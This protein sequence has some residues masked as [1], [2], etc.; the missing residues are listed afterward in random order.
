MSLFNLTRKE[1]IIKIFDD[2][3]SKENIN[4]SEIRTVEK[5]KVTSHEKRKWN[6]KDAKYWLKYNID[7]DIL[8]KYNVFPLKSFTLSKNIDGKIN[9][10][11]KEK[12]Y[13]YGYFKNDGSIYKIYQPNSKNPFFKVSSYIQGTE[14]LEYKSK[15]LIICSSLKDMMSLESLNFNVESIAPSSENTMIPK[16]Q[17]SSLILKYDNIYTLFDND[18]AGYRASDKYKNMYGIPSIHINLSKDISDS[19]KDF[20]ASKVKNYIN[21]LIP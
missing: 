15:T 17:I 5:Y 18:E 7:S 1:A 21:P 13:I 9:E 16:N 3:R 12:G 14:Q 10:F 8:E 19:I 6:V 20:T 11:K 4:I 2:Y